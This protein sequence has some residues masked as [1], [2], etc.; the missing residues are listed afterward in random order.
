MNY[1]KRCWLRI[2]IFFFRVMIVKQKK[3]KCLITRIITGIVISRLS[4][5]TKSRKIDFVTSF[6]KKTTFFFA[7][8]DI[9]RVCASL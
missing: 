4:K 1:L 5:N 9:S 6:S 7:Y 3:G 2:T 8:S